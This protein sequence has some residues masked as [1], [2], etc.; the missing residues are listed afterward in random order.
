MPLDN[1]L[2]TLLFIF[3]MVP[4][5]LMSAFGLDTEKMNII[6]FLIVWILLF[7]GTFFFLRKS[8]FWIKKFTQV[9]F[10]RFTK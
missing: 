6:P 10:C 8:I 7:V 2:L 4:D 5:L 1:I 9:F 3:V